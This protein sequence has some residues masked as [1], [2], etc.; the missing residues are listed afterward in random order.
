MTEETAVENGR[1]SNFEELVSLTLDRV[2]L[3]TVVHH[4]TYMPTFTEI[5]E[6]F[7]ERTYAQTDGHLR[8][9]LLFDQSQIIKPVSN[10]RPSVH[11]RSNSRPKKGN[12]SI[13]SKVHL[14]GTCFSFLYTVSQMINVL[15]LLISELLSF[16]FIFL[17]LR[18]WAVR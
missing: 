3:H 6:T 1:I 12:Y 13:E 15:M 5:E 7:C 18:F 11:D 14:A 8:P 9:A 4:F 2:K 17:I 10:V 16:W